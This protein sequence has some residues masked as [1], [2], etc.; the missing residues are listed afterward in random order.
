MNEEGTQT[1]FF[2]A[3]RHTFQEAYGPLDCLHEKINFDP[4][5]KKLRG[6]GKFVNAR[7]AR[8][9]NSNPKLRRCLSWIGVFRSRSLRS[10]D[11][12]T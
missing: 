8:F 4:C 7:S 10:L 5:N 1:T 11:R 6:M 12:K 2:K 9:T 3:L